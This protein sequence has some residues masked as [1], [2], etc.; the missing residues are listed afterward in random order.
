MRAGRAPALTL[1]ADRT[2]SAGRLAGKSSLRRLGLLTHSTAGFT[3]PGSC[4]HVTLELRNVGKLPMMQRPG[5]KIGKLCAFRLSS[6]SGHPY[7]SAVY[8]SR[9]RRTP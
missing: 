2:S 3:D 4:G 6:P 1:A 7:G 8:G 5:M 9:Y